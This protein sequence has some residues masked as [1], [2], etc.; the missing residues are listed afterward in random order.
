MVMNVSRMRQPEVAEV[1]KLKPQVQVPK[2]YSTTGK[3]TTS[4]YLHKL[5]YACLSEKF[6]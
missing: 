3:S 2:K 6:I 1:Y 5:K 4:K